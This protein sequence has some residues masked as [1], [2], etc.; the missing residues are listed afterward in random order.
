MND[1][2]IVNG[3]RGYYNEQSPVAEELKIR[4]QQDNELF[5]LFIGKKY[6]E[7][8]NSSFSIWALLLNYNYYLYRKMYFRGFSLLII[9]ILMFLLTS[10]LR[11]SFFVIVTSIINAFTFKKEYFSF[12]TEKIKKIRDNNKDKNYEE[13]KKIIVKNGGININLF[14]IG[15]LFSILSRLITIIINFY[16]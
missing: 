3:L 15:Y 7:I 10:Y 16:I 5:E 9:Y 14:V 2:K 13:L 6:E 12:A 11:A 1:N 8:L 4:L